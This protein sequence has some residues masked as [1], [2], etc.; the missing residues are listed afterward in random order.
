MASFNEHRE[1][2]RVYGVDFAD[3]YMR[4]SQFKVESF[5]FR[6]AKPES[7]LLLTPSK[8]QVRRPLSTPPFVREL[9]MVASASGRSSGGRRMHSHGHGASVRLLQRPGRRP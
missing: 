5:M 2:A 1:F 4:G 9:K 6:L 8:D 3:V 7:L